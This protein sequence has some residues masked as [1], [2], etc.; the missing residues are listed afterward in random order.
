MPVVE[1]RSLPPRSGVD[2]N[3]TLKKMNAVI[4]QIVGVP[5]RSVWSTWQCLA[6]EHYFEGP[7][8]VAE[9]PLAS[10]PPLVKFILF[11]GRSPEVIERTLMAMADV[12]VEGF[13]V[14]AGNV[15]ISV[16]EARSGQ[17]YTGGKIRKRTTNT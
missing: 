2:V 10:H 5:E 4:A 17:L 12:I 15:F 9:Q 13:K 7:I 1:V 16:H 6:T 8:G 11:E 3:Q 14:E